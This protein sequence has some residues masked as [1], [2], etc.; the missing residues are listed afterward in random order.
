MAYT[1]SALRLTDYRCNVRYAANGAVAAVDTSVKFKANFTN[2]GDAN[3]VVESPAVVGVSYNLLDSPG[4]NIT[5]AGATVT[6]AQLGALI[7][8]DAETRGGL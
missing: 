1:K 4:T 7:K 2:D 8:K 5:A 6:R 3:D